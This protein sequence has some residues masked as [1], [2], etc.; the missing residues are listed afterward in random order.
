[1]TRRTLY[2][3]PTAPA[4]TLDTLDYDSNMTRMVNNAVLPHLTFQGRVPR[5][6]Y[7]GLRRTLLV[8]D[9]TVHRTTVHIFP[10]FINIGLYF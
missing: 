2:V 9:N 3:K 7:Y 8:T 5:V 4:R 1:V 10:L 6:Q